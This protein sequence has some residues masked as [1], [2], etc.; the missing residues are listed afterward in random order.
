M[1]TPSHQP[2]FEMNTA[3]N[4]W[5]VHSVGGKGP[6]AGL[7]FAGPI[8]TAVYGSP[9]PL[10]SPATFSLVSSVGHLDSEGAPNDNPIF[11]PLTHL[12]SHAI[13]D[14][15]VPQEFTLVEKAIFA[16]IGIL[17]REDTLPNIT[18]PQDIT[19]EGNAPN[20]FTGTNSTLEAFLSAAVATDLF[21]QNVVVTSDAAG[22]LPLGQNTILFTATDASGNQTTAAANVT[23]QDTTPPEFTLPTAL[24]ISP[25]LPSGADLS[26]SELIDLFGSAASDIVD[27]TLTLTASQ[28]T[29]PVGITVVTFTATDDSGNA[30][31]AVVTLT[32]AEP[33]VTL[34]WVDP[35]DIV[36]GTV[37]GGDQ[38]NASADVAGTFSYTPPSGVLLMAGLNQTLTVNFTPDDTLHYSPISKTVMIDV[39]KADPVITWVAPGDIA[40]GTPLGTTQLDATTAEL[41]TFLYDPPAGTVLDVG[42]GQVLS[43]SFTPA[44]ADNFNAVTVTVAINVVDAQDYGDAPSNYPVTLANDGARHATGALRLGVDI[45]TELDGQPSDFADGDAA[46]DGVS[47]IA[48]LVANSSASTSA[49]VSIRASGSGML[50]GWI[51]FNQDGDWQDA[52]EQIIASA[53]VT[54][55]DNLISYTIPHGAIAGN[56]AARFRLSTSGGLA[57]TGAAADGEVEDY[58]LTLLDG[59]ATP[60]VSVDLVNRDIAIS[61]ESDNLVAR[62]GDV[63]LFASP[64]ASVGVLHVVGTFLDETVTLQAIGRALRSGGLNLQ[65]GNGKNTLVLV[66]EGGSFDLTAP[67]FEA[68][69]FANLDLSGSVGATVTVNATLVTKLSPVAKSIKIVAGQPNQIVFADAHDWLM[70][71]PLNIDGRF[72]RTATHNGTGNPVVQVNAP[73]P[74][75]NFLQPGDV[76]NDG[77]VTARDALRVINEL[78]RRE[79]SD[80]G[81]QVLTDAVAVAAW[82]GVYFDHNGDGRATAVDALRIINDLARQSNDLGTGE[83]ELLQPVA[84]E[85][86]PEGYD[87]QATSAAE[88]IRPIAKSVSIISS[89]SQRSTTTT[90]TPNR[91]PGSERV[92]PTA[93]S[94]G[95]DQLL[96][97]RCF[98]DELLR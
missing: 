4:G 81:D 33:N 21:D 36:F 45:D 7:F 38:L 59:D 23:V 84:I 41:G 16:D 48:S 93:I 77:F 32:V 64:D 80:S 18:A 28:Q 66:G 67:S 11:S 86:S 51:D 26:N 76:N 63:D 79:F 39:L 90:P 27:P 78:G 71:D 54:A 70:S 58:W 68:E 22:F 52:G 6:D 83:A 31:D 74:W 85:I 92:E 56:T 65:G 24:T 73:S 89:G 30:T 9:V 96:A 57:P 10:Y 88:A 47:W 40:F 8:A 14:R 94:V 12:M 46:D 61:V 37:L 17:F 43:A 1:P 91:L 75:Q 34:N 98:L 44:F 13:I 62:S 5:L 2:L 82:P 60:D 42:A 49:S 35:A 55:G 3:A 72:I 19:L 53:D 29:F 25:N 95:V 97:D 50:D 20:G 87:E 69:N 15:A